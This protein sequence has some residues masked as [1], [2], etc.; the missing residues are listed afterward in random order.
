[1]IRLAVFL[2]PAECSPILPEIPRI[3]KGEGNEKSDWRPGFK[4]FFIKKLLDEDLF[5]IRR[6][7]SRAFERWH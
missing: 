1:M 7:I 3:I 2:L 6:E 4:G 5:A